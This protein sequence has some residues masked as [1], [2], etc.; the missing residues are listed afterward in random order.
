MECHEAIQEKENFDI[1][2]P[3]LLL[4]VYPLRIRQW[5]K[6]YRTSR[7]VCHQDATS[8]QVHVHDHSLSSCLYFHF[9]SR[10]LAAVFRSSGIRKT[11]AA[12]EARQERGDSQ[13]R[14]ERTPRACVSPCSCVSSPSL[15]NRTFVPNHW[16][17]HERLPAMSWL[18][19]LGCTLKLSRLI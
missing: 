9:Q 3:F 5:D 11:G 10:C 17:T 6:L 2:I 19:P 12:S 16:I 18:L 4:K 1:L 14:G 8:M 15:Q 13:R 7:I